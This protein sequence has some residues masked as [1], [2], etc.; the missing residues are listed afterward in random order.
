MATI[1]VTY[2]TGEGKT[3]DYDYY[4]KTHVPLA[5]SAWTEFGL[6]SAE[7]LQPSDPSQPYAAMVILK[8]RDDAAIDAAMTSP[9]SAPVGADVP[10]FTNITPAIYRSKS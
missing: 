5:V 10:N 6:V 3:F 1:V 9:K 2:P 7:A 8:F 4:V